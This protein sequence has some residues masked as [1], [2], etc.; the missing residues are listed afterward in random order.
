MKNEKNNAC[1][2]TALHEVTLRRIQEHLLK[3]DEIQTVCTVF[4]LLAEPNRFKIVHALLDG[5][6]CVYH[7]AEIT[8]STVSATSHQLRVLKDNAIV[9]AKRIGKNVEYSLAGEHIREIVLLAVEHLL[10][11]Q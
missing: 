4:K 5:E 10:C 2:H 7:L 8:D 9:R 6:L 3:G 11:R 1:G